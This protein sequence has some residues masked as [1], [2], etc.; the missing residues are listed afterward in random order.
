MARDLVLLD[1]LPCHLGR[2]DV[3][4][5]PIMDQPVELSASLCAQREI[6][7]RLGIEV[8]LGPVD[9]SFGCLS[10]GLH[11]NRLTPASVGLVFPCRRLSSTPR[12]FGVPPNPRSGATATARET[13]RR[14]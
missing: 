9:Q 1:R 13:P 5:E 3:L 8:H 14:S 6:G 12:R 2:K 11:R 7:P 10:L 4:L